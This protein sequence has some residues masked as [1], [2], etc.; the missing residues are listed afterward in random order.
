MR[1]VAKWPNILSKSCG[2]NSGRFL[3]SVWLFY[4]IADERVNVITELL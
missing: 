1:N 4:N 3:K 2:V